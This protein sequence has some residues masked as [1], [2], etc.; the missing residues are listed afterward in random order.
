MFYQGNQKR[1]RLF[2]IDNSIFSLKLHLLQCI[3]LSITERGICLKPLE[4][5]NSITAKN[6]RLFVKKY[7]QNDDH[8]FTKL[9]TVLVKISPKI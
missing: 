3:R 6:S 2:N 4:H 5:V 8:V 7:S 1:L 9:R